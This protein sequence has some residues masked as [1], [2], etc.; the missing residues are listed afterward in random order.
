MIPSET[1]FRNSEWMD[2]W[3][4]LFSRDSWMVGWLY[5]IFDATNTIVG[6]QL[7]ES[8]AVV[9]CVWYTIQTNTFERQPLYVGAE[10]FLWYKVYLIECRYTIGTYYDSFIPACIM[11]TIHIYTS[12]P[13]TSTMCTLPGCVRCTTTTTATTTSYHHFHNTTVVC[14]NILLGTFS[15]VFF[16]GGR[17]ASM[18]VGWQCNYYFK[19]CAKVMSSP[20]TFFWLPFSIVLDRYD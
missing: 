18:R 11:H 9:A 17:V 16:W 12:L 10:R 7:P 5:I 13:S 8:R 3:V 4:L 14:R 6:C 20:R 15:F 1:T 19:Y 2:G